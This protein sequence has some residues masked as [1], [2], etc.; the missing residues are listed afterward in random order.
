[1]TRIFQ[2][3]N[4]F[5]IELEL[6]PDSKTNIAR[7]GVVDANYAKFR[8]DKAKVIQV[9]C[10]DD[11]S[12]K[13][14]E[15]VGNITISNY[16]KD[17]NNI[18]GQGIHFFLTKEPAFYQNKIIINGGFKKWYEN[19]Q[20][21]KECMYKNGLQHGVCKEWYGNGQLL[22]ESKYSEGQLYGIY[23]KW[24]R[25][26]NL[27]KNYHFC[28]GKRSGLCKE[29]YQQDRV[30]L[31]E[32]CIYANGELHGETKIGILMDKLRFNANIL[33]ICYMENTN[34]GMKMHNF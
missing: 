3:H 13:F 33:I 27:F 29:W 7:D 34:V 15:T 25:N 16:N 8:C 2:S 12:E 4:N 20:L 28:N 9:F 14:N 23:K 17:I 10:K 1:M 32:E 24:H 5:I 22:E 30:Q 11:P 31:Y 6:L 26:G 18:H 21:F 19:G